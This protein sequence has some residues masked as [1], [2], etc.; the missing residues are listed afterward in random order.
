MRLVLDNK[1][2]FM[3]HFTHVAEESEL[4]NRMTICTV[5]EGKCASNKRPCGTALA[6]NGVAHCSRKDNFNRP[7]GRKV[8]FERAIAGYSTEART[9][10][11]AAYIKRSRLPKAA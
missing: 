5:H 6:S 1:M 4:S 11:W 9:Q 7:K 10:L 2:E 8:A 3:V